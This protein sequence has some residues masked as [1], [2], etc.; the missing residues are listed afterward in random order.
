MSMQ[1]Q[2]EGSV[3]DQEQL[4]YTSASSASQEAPLSSSGS[5]RGF[6]ELQQQGTEGS[7]ARE[8]DVE[9]E[10]SESYDEEEK[11]DVELLTELR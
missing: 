11:E 5:Q 4:S 2:M 9:G 7:D 6:T 1:D 8:E 10:G 3:D